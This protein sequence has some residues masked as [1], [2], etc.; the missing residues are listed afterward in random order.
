VSDN[1]NKE[2][3]DIQEHIRDLM[4]MKT[5]L[6]EDGARKILEENREGREIERFVDLIMYAHREHKRVFT[7]GEGRSKLAGE[8]FAMRQR[9]M[10]FH[11]HIIGE[12]TTPRVRTEDIVIV[13]S[14]SG[15]T[16][17]NIARCQIIIATIKAKIVVIT[18][19]KDST[20]GRL[21]DVCIKLPG[22]DEVEV[23]EYTKRR[24][25]GASI[26]PLR[27]FFE[28]IA[29]IFLDSVIEKLMCL[30]STDEK[31]MEERHGI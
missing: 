6:I 25:V 29:G 3:E 13:I 8:A 12:S 30:T 16:D 31:A 28:A 4:I 24:L 21:A 26:L 7:G 27:T 22:R 10:G 23:V 18:S 17:T 19:H 15:E 20:L 1:E 14:G 5:K 9:Q 11:A 2:L